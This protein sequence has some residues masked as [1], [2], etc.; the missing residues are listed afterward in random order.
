MIEVE[1][2]TKYYGRV[3]AIRDV[4]FSVEQGEILG[5]LGPNGAGKTTTMRILTCFV[6]ATSGTA[7]VAGY[8]VF[9][10][11]LEVRK[12]IGYLPERVPL[13]KDMTTDAYLDFVAKI[14]G[15]PARHRKSKIEEVKENCGIREISDR[16][17]G[18]LSRGYVQRV[19][20]AQALLN[21]PDVLILDEPTV[22]LDPKQMIEIRNLI[23]NLAGKKTIILSTH[24]LPEVSMICDSVAIINGGCIAAKD[25][26]SRLGTEPQMKIH[27]VIRKVQDETLEEVVSILSSIKGIEEVQLPRNASKEMIDGIPFEIT[28]EPGA[29][30]RAEVSETVIRNHW[31][32]LELRTETFSLEDIFIKATTNEAEVE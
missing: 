21:D 31:E 28:S 10:Q 8:D 18:K 27:L 19:G 14:K 15:V 2:L 3:P 25:S 13:Y 4:S 5:F 32:L 6:P 22:G 9:T 29:D 23:R 12:R 1:N 16:L 17:I 26:I 24:I 7:R 11:S 30:P 20:I